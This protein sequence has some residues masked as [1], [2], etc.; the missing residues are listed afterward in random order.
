MALLLPMAGLLFA[1]CARKPAE[2][3][4]PMQALRIALSTEDELRKLGA[5]GEDAVRR[6]WVGPIVQV[7][8]LADETPEGATPVSRKRIARSAM[9]ID[10]LFESALANLRAMN[11]QSIKERTVAMAR[12]N[13]M[14]TRFGGDDTAARLLLPELWAPYAAG[15]GGKLFAAAPVRDML[16]WTTSVAEEDQRA[17]RGQARTAFQSRSYPISPAILRWTG[18]GWA[19][20]DANAVPGQ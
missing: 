15:A 17:L 20:E 4:L 2:P 11:K 13:V 18:G 10:A 7:L 5:H 14:I 1:A 9:T 3:E 6:P 12:G 8:V 16:I 19:L